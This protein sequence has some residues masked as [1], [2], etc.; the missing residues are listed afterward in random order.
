MEKQNTKEKLLDVGIDLVWQNNYGSVSVDEICKEAGAQKGSFYYY[1]N[2]KAEL[3]VEAMEHLFE[4]SRPRLDAAFSSSLSPIERFEKY[5]DAIYA[6]QKRILNKNG[7]VCGCPYTTLGSEMTHKEEII[8]KKAAEIFER[9]MKYY[10]SAL[11]DM[12]QEGLLPEDTDITKISK[13]IYS[14]VL[15]RVMM[16]RVQNNLGVLEDDFKSGLL[17]VVGIELKTQ[18]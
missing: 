7:H 15:G 8:R 13:D 1:F 17:R 2:S 11:T 18:Q 12:V 4:T 3:I 5:A 6:N 14:Y 16:A 9:F 10:S